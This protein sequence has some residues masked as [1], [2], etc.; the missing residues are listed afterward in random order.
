MLKI[1]FLPLK[2]LPRHILHDAAVRVG[3]KSK[4]LSLNL[5]PLQI[6]RIRV[7]ITPPPS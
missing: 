5:F 2:K 4:K 3:G 7:K 1:N 6:Q